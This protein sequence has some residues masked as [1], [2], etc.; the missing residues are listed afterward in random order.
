MYKKLN[1]IFVS[2]KSFY[3]ENDYDIVYS[4]A[5]FVKLL[6]S[7]NTD[8]N[9]IHQD[10]VLS[11]YV[12]Y[13]DSEI[14]KGN[15]SRFVI[16][17]KWDKNINSFI[18]KGLEKIEAYN[19]LIY[20]KN[21]ISKVESLRPEKLKELLESDILG[22][23]PIKSYLD[24]DLE[25]FMIDECIDKLNSQWLKNHKDIYPLPFN[26]IYIELEEFLGYKFTNY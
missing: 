22:I 12:D 20:F 4:N 21:M 15:F 3:S 11:Y 18:E 9:K 16:N 25:F 17:S 14:K 8:V 2:E 26:K 24:D 10:A 5:T 23:S 19:H 6:L 7:E 1:K 13:Y